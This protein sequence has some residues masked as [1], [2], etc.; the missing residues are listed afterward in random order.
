[1]IAGQEIE[2]KFLPYKN[3]HGRCKAVP[4]RLWHGESPKGELKETGGPH[5]VPGLRFPTSALNYGLARCE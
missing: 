2:D 1:M 5:S 3:I 4:V